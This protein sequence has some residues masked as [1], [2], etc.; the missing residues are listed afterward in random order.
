MTTPIVYHFFRP[1]ILV[2]SLIPLSC[3]PDSMHQ[4]IPRSTF[5]MAASG[6][7]CSMLPR[8]GLQW[9]PDHPRYCPYPIQFIFYM[10]TGPIPLKHQIERAT[11]LLE[12]RQWLPTSHRENTKVFLVQ[13]VPSYL[14]PHCSSPTHPT[15]PFQALHL[16]HMFFA[17]SLCTC[18]SCCSFPASSSLHRFSW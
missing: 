5:K 12:M 17:L 13:W 18:S 2:S 3:S 7:C 4:Q 11:P 15:S 9:A 6:P 1:K 10:E 16:A 8:L 14:L